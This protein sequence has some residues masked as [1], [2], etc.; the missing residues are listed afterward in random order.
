MNFSFLQKLSH[1]YS[2]DYY[3][4]IH[5]IK[6]GIGC[7]LGLLLVHYFNWPSGQWVPISV[8]VVMS[9]QTHFGGALQKAWMRFLGTLAGVLITILTLLFVGN[10]FL[11]ISLV[12]FV[13]CLIFTY[14][15]SGGGN[16]SYA[17]TLGGV[18][19]IL[20][21]TG[22]G[23]N[24]NY[25]ME[26]GFYIVVGIIIALLVSRL[27]FPIHARDRL[28]MKISRAMLDLKKLY[29]KT[30]EDYSAEKKDFF[31]EDLDRILLDNFT[32]QPS[33]IN[34]A[35]F[36]SRQFNHYKKQYYIEIVKIER[37]IYRLI[38]FMQKILTEEKWLQKLVHK[39]KDVEEL[40]Y[41]IEASLDELAKYFASLSLPHSEI[42]L[43]V[44]IEKITKIIDA[45][46]YGDTAEKII[47]EHSFLFFLEQIIKEVRDLQE[48]TLKINGEHKI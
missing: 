20:T 5:G 36:G 22:I 23:T 9:A 31:A 27:F 19:V 32:Q 33:L 41:T 35:A 39:I 15:A 44:S 4:V 17:G 7:L 25:A 40:N 30:L 38:Y 18:T 24:I 42:N 45:L 11:A 3:R 12:V 46:P 8:M 14:I 16:I 43:E 13:A 10:N 29:I 1:N 26:R 28:R 37:R 21:L 34:E 2:L 48:M 47:D 6:T